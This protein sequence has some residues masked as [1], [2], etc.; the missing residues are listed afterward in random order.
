MAFMPSPPLST[1]WYNPCTMSIIYGENDEIIEIT[2]PDKKLQ[3][4]LNKLQVKDASMLAFSQKRK[5]FITSIKDFKLG[6]LSLDET[7]EIAGFLW[8]SLDIKEK[9]TDL[10]D[11]LYHFAELNYYVRHVTEEN[12]GNFVWFMSKAMKYYEKHKA[13]SID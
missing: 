11:E 7:S 6:K 4:Y 1:I 8:N 5:I 3:Y 10:A 13:L 2:F 9:N 12:E